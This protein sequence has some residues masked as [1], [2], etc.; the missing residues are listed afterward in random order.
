MSEFTF[1]LIFALVGGLCVGSFLNVVIHRLPK[2]LDQRWRADC[3]EM[4]G[5]PEPA[6]PRYNLVVPRSV[7]R[8]V[9]VQ[10]L[11]RG[12]L[13]GALNILARLAAGGGT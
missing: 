10:D 5:Q 7:G 6:S 3:A 9:Y 2:M 4:S 13:E 1:M 11:E 8:T 12:E